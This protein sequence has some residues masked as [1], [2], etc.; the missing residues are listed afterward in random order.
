MVVN[1]NENPSSKLGG[2]WELIDK[3]F[4]N[5]YTSSIGFEPSSNIKNA[6]AAF[7]RSGHTIILNLAFTTNTE[8]TDTTVL[9]GTINYEEIGVSRLTSNTREVGFSDPGNSV[10]MFYVH[11]SSGEL[12]CVDVVGSSSV[13]QDLTCYA[14]IPFQ[15]VSNYMLDSACDKFYWERTA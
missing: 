4:S 8:L 7:S 15:F 2:T 6:T 12:S 9:L 1:T 11:Y 14:T 10:L 13:A 3:E 5:I